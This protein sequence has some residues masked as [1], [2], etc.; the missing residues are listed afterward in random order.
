MFFRSW[1]IILARI[2]VMEGLKNKRSEFHK[3]STYKKK[4]IK[5]GLDFNIL[6][7]TS[8]IL[9]TWKEKCVLVQKIFYFEHYLQYLYNLVWSYHDDFIYINQEKIKEITYMLIL[10]WQAF[11]KEWTAMVV[12]N[13][14]LELTVTSLFLFSILFT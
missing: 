13:T 2:S 5:K 3:S 9:Y 7:R 6:Q 12:L 1:R 14:Y 11:W 10:T 8:K 4:K